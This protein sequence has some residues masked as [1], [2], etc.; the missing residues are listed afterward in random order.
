MA[1]RGKYF[2]IYLPIET[3]HRLI[4]S[5]TLGSNGR[6]YAW[7]SRAEGYGRGEGV[8]TLLLKP[9]PAAL[10]DGD[11]VHAVIRESALNQD[12]R[13]HTMWSPSVDAQKALIEACYKRAGLNISDTAYVEAH[14]T[15]TLAGD[16]IEASALAQT[17]GMSRNAQDPVLVGSVKTIIGHTEAASGLAAVIKTIFALKRG[18]IPPNLNYEKPNPNIPMSNWHLA[19]PQTLTRWPKDKIFRASVN[20]FG[21]GGT[22]AHV[23]L[24]RAPIEGQILVGNSNKM[25]A[26]S[27]QSLVYVF[28]AK[29]SI[30]LERMADR[31]A[32]YLRDSLSNHQG[33]IA[34]DLAYTFWKR[35]SLFPW[36]LVIRA[37]NLPELCTKLASKTLKPVH[38]TKQP[39]LG[40]VFN[41]QGAQWYAMGRELITTYPFYGHRIHKA[42]QILQQYG[43]TWSLQG[44]ARPYSDTGASY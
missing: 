5:S 14:M 13:T 34:S 29:D 10:R 43:A 18:L 24:E 16:P 12:G 35:R 36:R 15:G 17:F 9:L 33:I 25:V 44:T 22:N 30:A 37:R 26:N 2:Q 19:V 6:C 32:A 11:R 27:E 7:D 42:G 4:V 40:F 28:S 1:H 39:R 31:F 3:K 8:A 41:G 21:Y 38:T 23:I 20:N